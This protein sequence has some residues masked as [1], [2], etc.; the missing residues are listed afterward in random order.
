M[1]NLGMRKSS[2]QV[3]IKLA[4]TKRLRTIFCSWNSVLLKNALDVAKVRALK[5][6]L[7]RKAFVMLNKQKEQ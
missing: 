4:T 2:D 7:L 1:K 3:K 6:L 5:K